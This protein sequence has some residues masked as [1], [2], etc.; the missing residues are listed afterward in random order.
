[1]CTTTRLSSL[2]ERMKAAVFSAGI[3]EKQTE[4]QHF[5]L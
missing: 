3:I 2:L 5:L 4:M 1:M